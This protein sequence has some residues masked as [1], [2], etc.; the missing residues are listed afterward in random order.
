MG[1][2]TS[3]TRQWVVSGI[4]L[5]FW[6]AV[7]L[8]AATVGG[9]ATGGGVEHWYDTLE[10]P[11]GTPPGWVFAPVWTVLYVLMAVAAWLVWLT[12]RKL[13]R[14]IALAVFG[15]QLVLNVFWSVIFFTWQE[16]GWAV[17]E[18]IAL[19]LAIVATLVL[20][21]RLRPLAGGLLIPYLAWV[22]YAVTLNIGFWSLNA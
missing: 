19:W 5:F 11:P 1:E 2:E 3:A 4:G 22:S 9:I 14:T 10:H 16:P 6:L 15:V 12:P 18:I 13:E 20:F 21:W 7:C 17:V 8:L